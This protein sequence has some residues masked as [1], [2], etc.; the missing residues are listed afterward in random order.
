MSSRKS[1]RRDSEKSRKIENYTFKHNLKY[2]FQDISFTPNCLY[3]Q[4]E[5]GKVE[6]S[7]S[8]HIECAI[9]MVDISGFS[10]YAS[11]LSTQGD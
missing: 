6:T 5:L 7:I 4:F 8:K 1:I 3:E 11:E 9:L 10:T 2:K